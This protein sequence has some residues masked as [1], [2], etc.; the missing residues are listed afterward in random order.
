MYVQ[1]RNNRCV[2]IPK[3]DAKTVII[4]RASIEA[5]KTTIREFFITDF[6][7]YIFDPNILE[8]FIALLN[9]GYTLDIKG[10]QVAS[11]PIGNGSSQTTT[12]SRS[13]GSSSSARTGKAI[14][15]RGV[16]KS[17]KEDLKVALIAQMKNSTNLIPLDLMTEFIQTA[18][19]PFLKTNM[20]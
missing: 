15:T 5:M 8:D 18:L 7:Y 17:F 2:A 4:P 10:S 12:S 9:Y 14:T 20:K 3:T 16:N 1:A 11:M 19:V 13:S 6:F